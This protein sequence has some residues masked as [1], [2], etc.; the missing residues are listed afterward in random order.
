MAID[1]DKAQKPF[2]KLSEL[3]ASLTDDPAVEDVH[4]LRTHTRRLEAVVAAFMLE[5]EKEFRHLLKL[6]V[7]IRKIAGKVRDMDVLMTKALTVSNEDCQD[8]LIRLLEHLG[9]MRLRSARKLHNVVA[10]DRKGL[11]RSLK[12][13]STRLED[14]FSESRNGTTKLRQGK[15]STASA[16]AVSI[17]LTEE[18]AREPRLTRRTIHPFR[19]RVKQLR[20]TLELFQEK[21]ATLVTALGEVKDKIGEWHDWQE[22]AAIA[23]KF[24][25]SKDDR[26]QL[27][28]VHERAQETFEQAI[29]SANQM[30]RRYLARTNKT[31]RKKK[32]TSVKLKSSIVKAVG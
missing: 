4:D 3:A 25:D 23:D 24:L 30:R 32:V 12:E 14:E 18:L 22:L 8:S 19:I 17:D 27:A 5:D 9:E 11:R 13:C 16:L 6:V 2:H 7:P 31:G 28:W 26:A 1:L 20:N 10:G 21:D 15:S 29:A